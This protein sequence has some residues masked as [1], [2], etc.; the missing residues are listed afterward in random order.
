MDQI[1]EKGFKENR[2]L[3]QSFVIDKKQS[4]FIENRK[5][6]TQTTRRVESFA[7]ASYKNNSIPAMVF[8]VVPDREEAISGMS[9]WLTAGRFLKPG[10]KDILLGKVL[11][12]NLGIKVG[13]TAVLIGRGYHGVSSAGI[14]KVAGLLDFPLPELNRQVIYMDITRCQDFFSM[15]DRITSY[16]IMVDDVDHLNKTMSS[17]RPTLKKGQRLYSWEEMQPELVNLIQGKQAGAK[18]VKGILFMVIGFGI[19]ATIIML[20]HERQRELGVMIARSH[21]HWTDRCCGGDCRQF[22]VDLVFVSKPRTCY[23]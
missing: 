15:S 20:M 14:F 21:V 2:S 13:D 5:A 7:L 17:I 12:E 8:G 1:Q 19:L 16:V 11:A 9:K 10:S 6:V 18:I 3:N 4:Q 23:R 22:P